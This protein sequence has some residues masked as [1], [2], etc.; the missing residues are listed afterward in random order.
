MKKFLITAI[1]LVGS[2]SSHAQGFL[3]FNNLVFSPT[4]I[5]AKV[6]VDVVGGAAA[7]TSTVVSLW[8]ASQGSTDVNSFGQ[9]F[10]SGVPIS[11]TIQSGAFAGYVANP[12]TV[13][14][15]GTSSGQTVAVALKAVDPVSGKEGWS[16]AIDVSLKGAIDV[17]TADMVGLLPWAITTPVV[18]EPSTIALGVVGGLLFMVRRRRA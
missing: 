12:G 8:F 10:Q 1:V 6:T 2:L 5:D 14:I 13:G 17:P 16:N 7:P 9:A 4:F 15:D 3:Q 18:P 11:K